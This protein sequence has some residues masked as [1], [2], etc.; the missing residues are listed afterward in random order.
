MADSR[1]GAEKVQDESSI[2][3]YSSSK[4]DENT[5][6]SLKEP[7]LAKSQVMILKDFNSLNQVGIHESRKKRERKIGRNG[8]K[9]KPF[10]TEES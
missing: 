6:A 1:V 9:E 7:T 8:E 5:E 10:L 2:S 3:C 4:T